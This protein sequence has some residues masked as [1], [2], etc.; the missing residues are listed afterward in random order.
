MPDDLEMK[1]MNP[2]E[3][4]E[5]ARLRRQKQEEERRENR[6]GNLTDG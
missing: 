4:E 5:E 2:A 3:L 1:V 6:N